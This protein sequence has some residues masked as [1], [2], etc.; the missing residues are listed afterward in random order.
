MAQVNA[1]EL[2][3]H[4]RKIEAQANRL[5]TMRDLIK[6]EMRDYIVDPEALELMNRFD[7]RLQELIGDCRRF[8]HNKYE[9]P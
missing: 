1:L 6:S 7:H 5:D 3:V 4:V 8:L 9:V 2:A